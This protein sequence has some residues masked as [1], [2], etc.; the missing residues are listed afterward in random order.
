M[1]INISKDA[2][3]CWVCDYHGRSLRKLI[4]NY[5]SFKDLSSWSELTSEV[6]VSSFGDNLFDKEEEEVEPS[7]TRCEAA[8]NAFILDNPAYVSP[9]SLVNKK[10]SVISILN[11]I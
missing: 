9:N 2:F 4:R 1:S 3:K 5:G 8:Y 7:F 10:I 6:D 11:H